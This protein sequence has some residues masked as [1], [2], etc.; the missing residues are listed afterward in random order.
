MVSASR[1]SVIFSLSSVAFLGACDLFGPDSTPEELVATAGR[2]QEAT[3][4]TPVPVAPAVKVTDQDGEP[5]SGLTVQFTVTGGGGS[6][7]GG[8]AKTDDSGVARV[9]SWTLGTAAGTNTLQATLNDLVPV[10]FTATGLAG[11]PNSMTL[12]E[13]NGQTGVVG[14]PVAVSP[15]VLLKDAYGNPVPQVTVDFDVTAGG[16]TVSGGSAVS[17]A[18]GIARVGAWT[19]GTAVGANTLAARLGGLPDIAFQATAEADQPSQITVVAGDN[20][21]A[22]VG[23]Q[24]AVAPL[25]EVA[26]QYGNP[27]EGL[28][29]IFAVTSGGGS[30]TGWSQ[31]TDVA[32]RAALGGWT[33]GTT[34]GTQ[35]L[36]ANVTGVDPVTITATARAGNPVSSSPQAG[37][38][39]S[40]TVGSAVPTPPAV[41]VEDAYGNGVPGVNVT[42]A[43]TGSP[44]TS[45]GEGTEDAVTGATTVT[46]AGGVA[47]VGSWTLGTVAGSYEL[48]AFIQGLGAPVIFTATA[49][50]D[51]PSTV[52]K[53]KGDGQ[54]AQLGTAVAIPPTVKVTDHFGNPV[55]GVSV[56]FA[57]AGGGGTVTGPM[58][59]TDADGNAAV[60]A[61]TLGG[62]AG[63][64]SLTATA[65]GVGSVT[66]TATATTLVPASMVK[67]AGDNQAVQ[68]G[69]SVPVAPQVKITDAGGNPVSG[70]SVTF[71]V[72][73]GGG[74]IT[75][76]TTQTDASGLASVGSWTLGTGA[77][78]NTLTAV[79]SGLTPATFTATGTA[80]PPSVMTIYAG[81]AQSAQV[82][83]AVPISPAVVVRD[84]YGN[85]VPGVGVTFTVSSGGGSVTGGNA[86]TN[87]AGIAAVGSWVLG[88]TAGTNTLTAS[89][90]G[91]NDVTFTATGTSGPSG[92]AFAV[93]LQFMSSIS[94]SQQSTFQSAASRW[95]QVIIG[96][97]PDVTST[98][99]A[100]GCQP[101]TES[102]G[103][104]DVKI[105]VTVEAIDGSGGV[106]GQAG[107]CYYRTSTPQPMPITG[108]MRFDEADLAD[109]EA[110]GILQDVIIHEMGHVLG[111]G[112]YWNGPSGSPNSNS[113][114]INEGGPDP[115]FNG[116]NAISAFDNAGGAGR[117]GSKV[118]VENTGGQ[119]TQDSHWRETVHNNELMTGWIE[120]AGTPN[121]LSIIT[122]GSLADLGY[123]VDMSAADPYTI[124]NPNAAPS[125][126]AETEG[127][128]FLKELPPPT[129][130]PFVPT[131]RRDPPSRRNPGG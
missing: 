8:T 18:A 52:L 87:S 26:D 88:P 78:T 11:Q 14:S 6:V 80:A 93:E 74:S 129:P 96:D 128:I 37:A 59:T 70:I 46:G 21:S 82:N 124:P 113:F 49:E 67:V 34:A 73:T 105:Y 122:V 55:G 121:P 51:T 112:T 126:Q 81:D 69:T 100:G 84:A 20:Q 56:T 17:D 131:T 91:I 58:A 127:K 104:D 24:I 43:E 89:S 45:L 7:I 66:F 28:G 117:V 90:S 61:W 97:V 19:L 48:T 4:G 10:T 33:L 9:G 101:V 62:T 36:S 102:G 15:S 118:P 125:L 16:G 83:T 54:T 22:T 2:N 53:E 25:V 64:N 109:M 110:S 98:L 12:H 92:G 75:G 114:L 13:G 1:V 120:P 119:G 85:G 30:I 32:G 99:F 50:A 107:P 65:D 57:V 63:T 111:I 94:P 3:V 23:T 60:G 27:L 39:Q 103:I 71:S 41:K 35:T 106:L 76:A 123:T 29:V 79:S 44:T 68:V 38:S 95:Q 42:F 130:I 86:T 31:T 40:V 108:I 116:V 47:T 115:Y 5:M 72:S 77:G